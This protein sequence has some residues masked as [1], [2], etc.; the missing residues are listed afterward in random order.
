A[1]PAIVSTNMTL[2]PG[3]FGDHLTS[4]AGTFDTTSQTKMSQWITKGASGTC[5]TVEEPCNYPGK[6]PAPFVH[7]Y[8]YKQLNLGE[9]C[10]RSLNFTPFQ[11][12]IYGDI[13][14]QPFAYRPNITSVGYP[15]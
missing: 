11:V 3:L 6:F 7:A 5:G 12:M 4:Y 9:A 8:Y 10:F 15:V 14:T 1:T 2:L 13:L